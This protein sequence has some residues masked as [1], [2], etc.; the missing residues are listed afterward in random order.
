MTLKKSSYIFRS[1]FFYNIG[2]D[3]IVKV[4]NICRLI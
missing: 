3:E 2:W 1:C 4:D